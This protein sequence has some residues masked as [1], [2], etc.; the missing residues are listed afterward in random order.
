MY[1]FDSGVNV[2]QL[3]TVRVDQTTEETTELVKELGR[4][5]A[6]KIALHNSISPVLAKE[7]SVLLFW[8][9]FL[10]YFVSPLPTNDDSLSFLGFWQRKLLEKFAVMIRSKAFSFTPTVF[11]KAISFSLV[12]VIII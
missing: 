10:F 4:A 12:V 11:L 8:L 7:R 9:Y 1:V 2:V 6:Y 3:R 5:D